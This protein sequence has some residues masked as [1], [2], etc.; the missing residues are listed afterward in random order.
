MSASPVSKKR[1]RD[2]AAAAQFTSSSDK[3]Q[4]EAALKIGE[5]FPAKMPIATVCD[6]DGAWFEFNYEPHTYN[7]VVM[8][9]FS[10]LSGEEGKKARLTLP[11][12][13]SDGRTSIFAQQ[14]RNDSARVLKLI[15]D[16]NTALRV[17][18]HKKPAMK[19]PLIKPGNPKDDGGQWEDLASFSIDKKAVVTVVLDVENQLSETLDVETQDLKGYQVYSIRCN[20]R[21]YVPGKRQ[22]GVSRIVKELVLAPR[23]VVKG[24]SMLNRLYEFNS[25]TKD[26]SPPLDLDAEAEM[27]LK[28]ETDLRE[29]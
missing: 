23:T 20:Y 3:K 4:R 14:V 8:T 15:E 29:L 10:T 1:A 9:P 12:K 26:P 13:D 25:Q 18:K 11:L 5:V 2:N 28:P 19:H 22:Y 17:T 27:E 21:Y 6:E 16:E 7:E 24:A